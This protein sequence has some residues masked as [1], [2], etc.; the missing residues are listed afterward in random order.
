MLGHT[1]C[2]VRNMDTA[3]SVL[4]WI[5]VLPGALLAASLARFIVYLGVFAPELP[6]HDVFLGRFVRGAMMGAMFVFALVPSGVGI[7]P[8]KKTATGV[9]ADGSAGPD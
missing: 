4:R 1:S 3:I 9:G 7:A 8:S 2:L 5:A 6:F